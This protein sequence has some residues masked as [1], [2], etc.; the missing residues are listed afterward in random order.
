MGRTLEYPKDPRNT[1]IRNG[2]N[3]GTYELRKIHEI[4]NSSMVVHVSFSPSPEDIFPAILPMIGAMGAYD[5]PS[6]GLEEPMDC[7]LHGY[8]SSRIMRLNR[9]AIAAGKKGLPLCIAASKVDGL[10]LA[11]TSNAHSYN[12]RSAALFGYADLV[13]DDEEKLWAMELIT[14]KVV[15]GRWDNTR[16]PPN[17][18]EMSSTQILRVRIESGSGKIRDGPPAD[19]KH[20]LSDEPLLERVWTGVIPV[21]EHLGEP[22]PSAYNKVKE[23]PQHVAEYINY[24]NKTAKDYQDSLEKVVK[25]TQLVYGDI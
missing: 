22:V 11:L 13:T 25:G 14:N 3:R 23:I 12:Y 20:D 2:K 9:E 21:T 6:A 4:V 19:D 10:V 24:T 16:L 18:G 7:Y 8:V 15:A 1:V 17:A 5:R